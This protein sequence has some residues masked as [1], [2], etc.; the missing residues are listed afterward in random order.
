[1]VISAIFQTESCQAD[2][3]LQNI[4]LKM[5][6]D[7]LVLILHLHIKWSLIYLQM[8]I[9]YLYHQFRWNIDSA[10]GLLIPIKWHSKLVKNKLGWAKHHM[11]FPLGFPQRFLMHLI[12]HKSRFFQL[13][14]GEEKIAPPINVDAQKYWHPKM[15]TTK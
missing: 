9:T 3:F 6:L 5:T 2:R 13:S 4:H 11:I 15:L 1:M 12:K 14:S 7:G 10:R 8:H